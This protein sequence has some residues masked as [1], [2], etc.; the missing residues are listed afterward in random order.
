MTGAPGDRLGRAG[1]GPRPV[2]CRRDPGRH[3][4]RL[5]RRTSR[6]WS[7]LLPRTA[8]RSALFACVPP[9]VEGSGTDRPQHAVLT[10]A[11]V[12]SVSA[13]CKPHCV[14]APSKTAIPPQSGTS[15]TRKFRIAFLTERGHTLREIRR[16]GGEGLELSFEVEGGSQIRLERAVEQLLGQ[17]QRTGGTG[18]QLGRE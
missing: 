15:M 4:P 13:A 6:P 8:G 11:S 12:A 2:R 16:G 10:C 5:S 17:A 18:R 1:C 14:S 3:E 7:R 9:F